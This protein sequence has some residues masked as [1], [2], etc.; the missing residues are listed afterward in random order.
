MIHPVRATGLRKAIKNEIPAIN[1]HEAIDV[2]WKVF[3][4]DV[5]FA[6]DREE[7]T[8]WLNKRY[9]KMLLGGKHGGLNDFH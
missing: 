5:F 8:L 7:K 6:I 9:R 3:A 1:E 4:D 2:R